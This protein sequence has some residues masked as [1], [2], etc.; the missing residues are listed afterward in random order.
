MSLEGVCAW[1]DNALGTLQVQNLE[2]M[3]ERTAGEDQ[4]ANIEAETP[5]NG[6]LIEEQATSAQPQ[7]R[8][9]VH[10]I[11][12]ISRSGAVIVAHLMRAK[13]LD[14]PSALDLARKSRSII[15]PNS[16][17]GDQLRL[18][19]EMDYTIYTKGIEKDSAGVMRTTKPQYEQWRANRGIL[20]SK[21]EEAKQQVMRKTMA[22]MAAQFGK[23]RLVLKEQI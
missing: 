1:I 21:G 15:T 18:W 13:S 16:G 6:G 10:C 20:L 4:L 17:F 2:S 12:G 19:K 8:V 3:S 14:Y 23:R 11:Q 5:Q 9:L 7:A 22:A